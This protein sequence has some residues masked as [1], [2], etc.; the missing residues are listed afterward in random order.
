MATSIKDLVT[1]FIDDNPDD[2]PKNMLIKL[3]KHRN[4]YLIDEKLMP[5]HIFESLPEGLAD[6]SI[7]GSTSVAPWPCKRGSSNAFEVQLPF[8]RPHK[9]KADLVVHFSESASCHGCMERER[10]K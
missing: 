1:T 3:I 6:A 7:K 2:N 10:E 9:P 4:K 8:L 5:S